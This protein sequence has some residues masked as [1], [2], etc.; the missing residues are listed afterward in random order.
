MTRRLRREGLDVTVWPS[1]T[2]SMSTPAPPLFSRTSPV[3]FLMT[4]GFSNWVGF[5]CWQALIN[6]FGKDA[7]FTGFDIGLMQSVRE[8]PG[9]LAFTAIILFLFMREQ[10]LAYLSLLMLGLGIALTGFHPSLTGILITTFIMSV[11]FH[12]FET[13]QQALS[14]QV[15][16]KEHAAQALGKVASAVAM[17]QLMSFGAVALAWHLFQPSWQVLFLWAGGVTVLLTAAAWAFFPRFQGSVPQNKGLVLRQRYWLYYALTFMSGARRQIFMA[18]G[19][20]LLVERFGYDLSAIATLMLVTYATNV[21]AAPVIGGLIRKLGERLTIQVE[22]VSLVVVFF[23][24]ALASQGVFGV[25][26][27]MVVGVLFIIDGIFVTLVIAQKTY[28]QKIAD[29]ADIAPTAAVAFSIN[30]IAAVALPV[31]F[32]VLWTRIDPSV[33]FY[34]GMGIASIS[35]LLAFLVPRHP[36]PGAETTMPARSR[37]AA[38]E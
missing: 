1:E 21:F 33:V 7:G 15:I 32:G 20:F 11:G 4:L 38:A 3:T 22:N 28:F 29:A 10:L 31:T 2:L 17:A 30:H 24:Y 34:I 19:G 8:I 6:N 5:A 35:L 13:A 12:Y 37:P 25:S 16:P 14:L 26:G 9:F 36:A 18:F 23:G 27:A